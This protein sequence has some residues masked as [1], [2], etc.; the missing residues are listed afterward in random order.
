MIHVYM[1]NAWRRE[2]D[3]GSQMGMCLDPGSMQN[4][5]TLLDSG[6]FIEGT[7]TSNVTLSPISYKPIVILVDWVDNVIDQM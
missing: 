3:Q 7:Y 4:T 5:S 1:R 2:G 6:R